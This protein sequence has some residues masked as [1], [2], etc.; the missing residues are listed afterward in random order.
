MREMSYAQLGAEIDRKRAE[1]SPAHAEMMQ[2][3][4]MFSFPVACLVFAAIALPLG[5]NTRK[6]GRLAGLTLGLAVILAYYVVMAVAEAWTKGLARAGPADPELVAA[7]AR[8]VPNIVLGAVG[9]FAVWRRAPAEH[10]DLTLRLPAWARRSRVSPPR[11]RPRRPG[12]PVVVLRVPR[13]DLPLP[14]AF[15]TATSACITCASVAL[16][17]L[18]LLAL[19]Y[20]GSFV[21]PRRQALQ[22]A[23]R[24]LDV[25]E[26]PAAL[27]AAVHRLRPSHRRC[28]LRCSARSAP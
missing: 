28:S 16:A 25:R 7:L 15:W 23:G 20:I 12:R 21:G 3:Q 10:V 19:Y 1:G 26:L 4:Q 22:A 2:Q 6:E 17:F 8:W 27:D 9:A 18:G 13:L 24:R 14:G 5:L 11:P